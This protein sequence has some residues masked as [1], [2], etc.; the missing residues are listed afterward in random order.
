MNVPRALCRTF[1]GAVALIASGCAQLVANPQAPADGATVGAIGATKPEPILPPQDLTPSLLYQFLL[2]EMAVHRQQ[3]ALAAQAYVDLARKTLDPRIARRATDVAVYARQ[4]ALAVEAAT[5]W[6]QSDPNS[7]PAR[8]TL[9]SILVSS[10]ALQDVRPHLEML[11]T[12][13]PQR[14]AAVFLQLNQM[15]ARHADKAQVAAVVTDLAGLHPRIAEGRLAAA[16]A[17]LIAKQLSAALEQ[18]RLALK[19]RPDW[20]Q[21]ALFHGQ[22]LQSTSNASAIQYYREYLSS[23]PNARDLRLN[24]ARLLVLE[25]H[26]DEAKRELGRLTRDY[27]DNPDVILTA[28]LLALQMSDWSLA[29]GLLTRALELNASGADNVRFYLGQISEERKKPEDALRWYDGVTGGEQYIAAR[30]RVAGILAKQG[31]LKEARAMLQALQPQDLQ[32]RVQLAQAEAHIL[33]DA[34]AYKEA[35]EL[36][37]QA[38]EKLPNVPELLYDYAMAAEKIDRLDVLESNLRKLIELKPDHAHAYN[39]LGYTLADRN[40]RLDEAFRLI[41]QAIALAPDD[42]FIQDSMGWVLY[43]LGRIEEGRGY[44]ERA[45]KVRPDPEIAAHLGEVLWV[46]GQRD[47]AQRIWKDT[48][49]THP[50]NDVLESVIKKFLK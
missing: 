29:E 13:D 37:G 5:L 7:L 41:E 39:A 14:T 10:G 3:Y 47:E 8:Q 33:R 18:S 48:L 25:K 22:I 4:V 35:F 32:Q 42:P 24:L 34:L 26:N 19:L 17:H 11:L 40:Q 45:F 46:Q 44:L 27:S 1:L 6:L 43:R 23:Y 28:G 16:Q 30:A 38:V 9:A 36:L 31:R 49:K 12:V 50:G 2:A 20:E 21:A 15:L